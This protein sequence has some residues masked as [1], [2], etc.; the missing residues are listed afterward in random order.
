MSDEENTGQEPSESL[1]E[2][3]G[4]LTEF[5]ISLAKALEIDTGFPKSRTNAIQEIAESLQLSPKD[6]ED[7]INRLLQ[8][9]EDFN[10]KISSSSVIEDTTLT[11]SGEGI[12]IEANHP[13]I[14]V[15]IIKEERKESLSMEKAKKTPEETLENK[16]PT[17]EEY[18]KYK[19]EILV[20]NAHSSTG[21]DI[22]LS[23]KDEEFLEWSTT[24]EGKKELREATNRVRQAHNKLKNPNSNI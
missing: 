3:E 7:Q 8:S 6:L 17:V 9:V 19:N 5:S 16:F 1:E 13:L 2:N 22:S 4:D 18:S 20:S 23:D 11:I 14:E 21:V 12:I 24:D 10:S 15:E